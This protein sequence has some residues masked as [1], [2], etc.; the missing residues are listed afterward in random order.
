MSEPADLVDQKVES[1]KVGRPSRVWDVA[2]G[3]TW[4]TTV[5]L[6]AGHGM[7]DIVSG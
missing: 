2:D 1:W 6:F 4:W 3:A 5:D 7:G